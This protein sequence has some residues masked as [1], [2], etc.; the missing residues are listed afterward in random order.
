MVARFFPKEIVKYSKK[1]KMQ[2]RTIGRLSLTYNLSQFTLVSKMLF[3][4]MF[5]EQLLPLPSHSSIQRQ[6]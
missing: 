4:N 6:S 5:L 3:Q 1:K 2:G